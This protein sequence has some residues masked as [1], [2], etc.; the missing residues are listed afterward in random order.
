MHIYFR[1]YLEKKI[2]FVFVWSLLDDCI[3]SEAPKCRALIL[4]TR[5]Q[6]TKQDSV[7]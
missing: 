2:Q 1:I 3:Y 6:K 7:I 4:P 5:V